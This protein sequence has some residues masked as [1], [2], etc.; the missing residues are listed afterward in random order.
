MDRDQAGSSRPKR[1][2]VGKFPNEREI[3]L[4][5][6]SDEEYNIF[7][8]D[9]SDSECSVGILCDE[10]SSESE[11]E[12]EVV[13]PSF[14]HVSNFVTQPPQIVWQ[15]NPNLRQ[16]PFTKQKQLIVPIPGEGNPY[17]FLDFFWT[18]HFL[19]YW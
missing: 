15:D 19:I 14:D 1:A 12:D 16:F 5:L 6:D 8:F 10:N 18:T 9:D 7:D 17:D 13:V 3:Q 2:C 11:D 4:L